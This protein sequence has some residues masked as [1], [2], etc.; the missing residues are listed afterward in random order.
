MGDAHGMLHSKGET[1]IGL[2]VHHKAIPNVIVL[3]PRNVTMVFIILII[4]TIL[5]SPHGG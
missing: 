3:R 1:T 4:G 5:A 2:V